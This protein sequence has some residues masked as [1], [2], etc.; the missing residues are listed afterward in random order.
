[1]AKKVAVVAGASG[2]VRMRPTAVAMHWGSGA[3]RWRLG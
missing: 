2:V 3:N 1:M